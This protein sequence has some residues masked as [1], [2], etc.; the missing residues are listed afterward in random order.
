ML[1]IFTVPFAF[2][3]IRKVDFSENENRV[4]ASFPSFSVSNLKNSTFTKGLED[5]MIDHFPI[6]DFF[7][8]LKTKTEILLGKKEINNIYVCKN[9]YYMDVYKKPKNTQN[10]I[11][12]VNELEASLDNAHVELMVVPTA[13]CVYK[14]LLPKNSLCYDQTKIIKMIYSS[15]NCDTID[16][17][18]TLIEHKNER[19]LYYKLDHHWKTGAAYLAYRE[20]CGF[21]NIKPIEENEFDIKTVTTSFKGTTFSKVNDYSAKGESIECYENPSLNVDVFYNDTEV[22]SSS[23][24][25]PNYLNKKDKYS[26]FLN[27][28]HYLL[29]IENKDINTDDEIV[30][31]KDSY[32]NCFIPFL[33]NHYKKIYV[34]DPRNYNGVISD[35]INEHSNVKTV[36]VLYN[37]STI[38]TDSGVSNIF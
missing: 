13:V 34:I 4:L 6:R 16:V 7:V 10:L 30:V 37:V 19:Q 3:V 12:G 9:G 29:T 35:F 32:A 14:E 8:G 33:A 24:Y 26:F 36:L 2:S 22:H 18:N 21:N 17:Y 1:A 28:L 11:D 5:Y 31:V 20:Y 15:V 38:D 27:N 23:M 25:E